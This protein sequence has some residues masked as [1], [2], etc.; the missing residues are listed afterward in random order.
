V[1]D[2][3]VQTPQTRQVSIG[4][5]REVRT[6]LALSADFVNS[7]GYHLYNAPDVNSV[8]PVTGLR[9]NPDFLR[10][11]RYETTGNS[12]YRGLL[13]GLERRSGRGPNHGV[14]YT[15]SRLLRD[16]EDFQSRG[17]DPLDRNAEK[18]LGDNNRTHQFVANIT[19]A[20]PHAFQIGAVLQMRSGLPW[21]VTNF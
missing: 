3:S 21:N 15:L 18:A 14:S 5:K 6:G 7:R 17:Q 20:L 19:W 1:V 11:T 9:P 2:P 16:V 4:V 10:I 13:V 8:D 12:W